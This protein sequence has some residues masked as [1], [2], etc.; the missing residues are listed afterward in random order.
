MTYDAEWQI[1][2]IKGWR[3]I[4]PVLLRGNIM[5]NKLRIGNNNAMNEMTRTLTAIFRRL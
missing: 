2:L 1:N 4:L 5:Y 3:N